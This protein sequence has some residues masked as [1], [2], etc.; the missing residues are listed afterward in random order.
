MASL[1][2]IESV[3]ASTSNVIGEHASTSNVI[4]EGEGERDGGLVEGVADGEGEVGVHHHHQSTATVAVA[5]DSGDNVAFA[6]GEGEGEGEGEGGVVEAVADGEGE[7]GVHH[8]AT[9]AAAMDSEDNVPLA[10]PPSASDHAVAIAAEK[11]RA[12]AWARGAGF[13]KR[14]KRSAFSRHKRSG[15][16]KNSSYDYG[17][18][19]SRAAILNLNANAQTIAHSIGPATQSPTKKEYKKRLR[20]AASDVEIM[21]K[22]VS[23]MKSKMNMMKRSHDKC[24]LKAKKKYTTLQKR[25]DRYKQRTRLRMKNLC[26]E[27]K[28]LLITLADQEKASDKYIKGIME[29]A[30]MVMDEAR[31]IREEADKRTDDTITAIVEEQRRSILKVREVRRTSSRLRMKEVSELS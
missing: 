28:C 11:S 14:K 22:E 23:R 15:K 29:E 4:G 2:E 5:M 10:D 13:R 6:I 26:N 27:K 9:V 21:G 16:S 20:T 8:Q 7:V 12:L 25:H 31:V 1:P 30:D 17:S 3:H 19:R 18:A 24:L